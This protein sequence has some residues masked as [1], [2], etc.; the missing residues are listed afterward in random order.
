LTVAFCWGF[1]IEL[2][3]GSFTGACLANLTS[4]CLASLDDVFNDMAGAVIY[5]LW[6]Q[7]CR[8]KR[9]RLGLRFLSLLPAL[10]ALPVVWAAFDDYNIWQDFPVLASFEHK[11]ELRRWANGQNVRMR[12]VE[13]MAS[14]GQYSAAI[15]FTTD[16][17]SRVTMQYFYRDWRGFS[18]LT[19]DVYNPDEP[20]YLMIKVYDRQHTEKGYYD[21]NDRYNGSRLLEHGWNEIRVPMRDIEHSPAGRLMELGQIYGLEFFLMKQPKPRTLFIDNIRLTQ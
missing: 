13:T 3:Q 8:G 15:D 14:S 7:S 5:L 4:D 2:V 17:Y 6:W 1:G 19:A 20:V 21:F 16:Q 18:A 11:D 12:R 10:V 9:F